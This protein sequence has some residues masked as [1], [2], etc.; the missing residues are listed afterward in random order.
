M[1]LPSLETIRLCEKPGDHGANIPE[2]ISSSELVPL[3]LLLELL[4]ELALKLAPV[5]TVTLVDPLSLVRVAV[6]ELVAERKS[7][8]MQAN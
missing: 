8:L 2:S 4:L 6:G 5:G 3:E 1:S 7:E